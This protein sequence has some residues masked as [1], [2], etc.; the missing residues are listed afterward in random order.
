MP[1]FSFGLEA[2]A[3]STSLSASERSTYDLHTASNTRRSLPLAPPPRVL[4][5]VVP[6]TKLTSVAVT[7][8]ATHGRS[9][10][11]MPRRKG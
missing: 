9:K 4:R 5:A 2:L 11:A 7:T 1:E 6:I 8:L 10:V 3:L